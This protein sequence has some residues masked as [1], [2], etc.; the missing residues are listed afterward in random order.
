[1]I[2][3]DCF[4]TLDLVFYQSKMASSDNNN[5]NPFDA[6]DDSEVTSGNKATPNDPKRATSTRISGRRG[7]S[8]NKLND[9]VFVDPF[10]IALGN[11]SS[12]QSKS[13]TASIS[14]NKSSKT[15][16]S[17]SSNGKGNK[18]P[19]TDDVDCSK[20]EGSINANVK[21]LSCEFCSSWT[22]LHCSSIPEQ[23]YDLMVNKD[24]PN[25]LWTCDSCIHALPTIT[26]LG[27][28]LQGVKDDQAKCR[29]EFTQLSEKVDDLD[30]TIEES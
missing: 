29:A 28:T 16:N 27:R 3:G 14:S 23:L 18:A 7:R 5:S 30:N 24:I 13:N 26:N 25:F 6:N 10:T 8:Q 12:S 20:C 21:A 9:D 17:T 4:S 1:M 15:K 11:R 2:F 22:C 19:K